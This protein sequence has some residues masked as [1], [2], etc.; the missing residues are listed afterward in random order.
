M[1]M[2]M[3]G[4]SASISRQLLEPF[5]GN[6]YKFLVKVAENVDYLEIIRIKTKTGSERKL[7]K[8]IIGKIREL[9]NR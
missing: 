5:E 1:L 8:N 2:Q 7:G 9:M 4:V 3:P 6:I